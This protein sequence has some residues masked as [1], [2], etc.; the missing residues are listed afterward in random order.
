MPSTV[1]ANLKPLIRDKNLLIRWLSAGLLGAFVIASISL[2]HLGGE[3]Y[4]AALHIDFLPDKI[5]LIQGQGSE[6]TDSLVINALTEDGIALLSSPRG[7]TFQ[8]HQLDRFHWCLSDSQPSLTLRLLWTVSGVPGQVYSVDLMAKNG[9]HSI[10]L[11]PFENWHGVADGVGLQL[12]GQLPKP[13]VLSEISLRPSPPD[14][15]LDLFNELRRDWTQHH[16]WQTSEVHFVRLGS[17]KPL[18]PLS[19]VLFLWVVVSSIFAGLIGSFLAARG[20]RARFNPLGTALLGFAITAWFLIDGFWQWELARRLQESHQQLADKS[21]GERFRYYDGDTFALV[22]AVRAALPPSP[23]RLFILSSARQRLPKLR[24]HYHL[25]PHNVNSQA[26]LPPTPKQAR[27]GDYILI[28]GRI[29]EL[30][31]YN[32]RGKEALIWGGKNQYR[33]AVKPLLAEHGGVLF[34]IREQE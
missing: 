31:Y 1:Q 16:R 14:N 26:H 12:E 13:V 24:A 4:K 30:R 32:R 23:Q 21:V 19:L 28:L 7:L 22:E 15:A 25:L 33:L 5:E 6:Q 11:R 2:W 34:M 10:N 20:Q 29:E 9:C 27:P 18:V 8:T 17:L 3:G